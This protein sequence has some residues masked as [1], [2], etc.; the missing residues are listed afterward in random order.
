MDTIDKVF[1]SDLILKG[2]PYR[3]QATGLY[4]KVTEVGVCAC[5]MGSAMEGAAGEFQDTNEYDARS[6]DMLIDAIGYDPQLQIAP[7]TLCWHFNVYLSC[8][9][10]DVVTYMND[11][12]KRTR[13]EIA[14]VLKEHGL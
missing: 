1:L 11:N 9:V 3:P 6:Y 12:L 5:A 2:I 14:A 8:T 13:E 4:F 10:F 7:E